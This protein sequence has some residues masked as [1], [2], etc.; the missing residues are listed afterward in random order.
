[1]RTSALRG[2]GGCALAVALLLLGCGPKRPPALSSPEGSVPPADSDAAARNRLPP[3]TRVSDGPDVRSVDHGGAAG[4]D[5]PGASDVT[6][7]GGPL[8]DIYFEYDHYTLTDAAKAILDQHAAWIKG[9]AQVK[10]TVEG[11]CD[12]RGTV[13][14]NLALGDK[15]A[16]AA[17][18]Y[19]V[20]QGVPEARLTEMSV[21][22]ERP[23]DPAHN[24]AAWARNRRDHFAVSR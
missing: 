5:I 4:E 13:E 12:E 21:G 18:D 11:H 3:A 23:L 22:K 24:E 19:L 14:Y 20:G 17:R 15:R 16:R 10:V 7:E 6:T 2:H 8:A 9:H 1:M